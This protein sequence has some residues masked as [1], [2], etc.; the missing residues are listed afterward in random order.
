[1]NK[2]DIIGFYKNW[3]LIKVGEQFCVVNRAARKT[4]FEGSEEDATKTFTMLIAN[5]INDELQKTEV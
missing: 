5:F 1:M 3:I 2:N 4:L